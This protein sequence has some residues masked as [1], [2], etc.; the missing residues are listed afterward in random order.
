MCVWGGGGDIR[1]EVRKDKT[2]PRNKQKTQQEKKN[3]TVYANE[4]RVC[5]KCDA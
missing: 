1:A 3:Y 5:N 4:E 2:K